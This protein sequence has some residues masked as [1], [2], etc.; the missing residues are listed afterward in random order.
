MKRGISVRD[1]AWLEMIY[2]ILFLGLR[3]PISS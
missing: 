1:T 3:E 2:V